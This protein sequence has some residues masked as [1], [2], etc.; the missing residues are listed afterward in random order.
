MTKNPAYLVIISVILTAAVV[1][2]LMG[3]FGPSNDT[4]ARIAELEGDVQALN[5]ENERLNELIT[6][7]DEEIQDL[8]DELAELRGREI[9]FQP[10]PGWETYFPTHD[11][12]TITGQTV[13]AVEALLGIPPVRIRSTAATTPFNREIWVFMPY[14][15]DPTGLYL[16]FKGDQLWRSRLDEFTGIYG[17]GL[18][19]NEEFWLN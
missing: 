13:A 3:F 8:Q 14:L 16:F 12:N 10:K 15:E 4:A 17:S 9:R 18:L 19:E 6:E 7:R 1:W 5:S 11:T 2:G